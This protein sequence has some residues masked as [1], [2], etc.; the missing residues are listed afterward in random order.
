MSIL[1][2]TALPWRVNKIC[3]VQSTLS[4]FLFHNENTDEFLVSKSFYHKCLL[5]LSWFDWL[6]KA[7]AS[8]NQSKS[9]LE[10]LGRT[11]Q[12]MEPVWAY[13]QLLIGHW[14]CRTQICSNSFADPF[15]FVIYAKKRYSCMVKRWKNK[16]K[17]AIA[18][19]CS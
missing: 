5:D 13:R 8:N 15:C 19:I 2:L 6:V 7:R 9:T 14:W 12:W 16:H 10:I 3:T 18:A 17:F 1:M 11:A 4:S